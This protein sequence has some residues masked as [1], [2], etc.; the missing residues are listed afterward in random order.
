MA[1][2]AAP[3]MA[4]DIGE[5]PEYV[6]AYMVKGKNGYSFNQEIKDAIVFEYHDVLNGNQLPELDFIVARDFISFLTV[7][8]Q[9]RMIADFAERLKK[10]GIVVA[11]RNEQL[12]EDEW[13]PV[14]KDP[15]SAFLHI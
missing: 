15:V 10:Q 9:D 8:E 14:A 12:P 7:Q 11:G 5:A 2:A 1:I 6:R 13:Q 3:N 4:F